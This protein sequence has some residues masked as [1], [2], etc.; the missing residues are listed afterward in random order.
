MHDQIATRELVDRDAAEV[1]R[2][3]RAGD[4]ALDRRPVNLEATYAR[5]EAARDHFDLVAER[6]LAAEDGP[7]DDRAEAFDRKHAIDR[8]PKNAGRGARRQRVDLTSELGAQFRQAVA[9]LC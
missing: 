8:E 5:R 9:G 6:D 1:D 7:G 4:R 2:D 3:A